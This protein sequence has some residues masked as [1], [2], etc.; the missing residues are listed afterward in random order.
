MATIVILICYCTV[1]GIPPS[2]R[3]P[4]SHEPSSLHSSFLSFVI[5]THI[6]VSSNSAL[7]GWHVLK[8]YKFSHNIYIVCNFIS[9]LRL[10]CCGLEYLINYF[11]WI[12]LKLIYCNAPTYSIFDRYL[13]CLQWVFCAFTWWV[14]MN[15][16]FYSY[17]FV[18]KLYPGPYTC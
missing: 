8:Q 13:D 12:V 2:Q 18:L 3:H 1:E 17:F 15:I 4:V 7:L 5:L 11:L 9:L 10:R 16:L 14:A 6:F